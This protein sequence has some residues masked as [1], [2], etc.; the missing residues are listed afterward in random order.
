MV[1]EEPKYTEEHEWV[2]RI[3]DSRVRIGLTDHAQS[4]LGD[5]VFVQLLE[6]GDTLTAGQ[7]LGQVESTK[8]A[9]DISAPLAGTVVAVNDELDSSPETVNDDCYGD[10]R[11]LEIDLDDVAELDGLL[12]AA[13]YTD[14][15]GR[16]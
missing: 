5:I 11:L 12:D 6:A 9:S 10:G 13:E 1:P 3:S 15:I 8:A 2:L 7:P 14:L 16:G 4:Q